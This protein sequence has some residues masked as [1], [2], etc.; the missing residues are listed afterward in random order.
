[1]LTGLV[2]QWLKSQW[3]SE[4]DSFQKEINLKFMASVDQVIDS[5]LVKHLITPV[6]KDSTVNGD[7]LITFNKKVPQ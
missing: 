3:Q 4:K 5:M 2:A 7:N 6:L 1:M